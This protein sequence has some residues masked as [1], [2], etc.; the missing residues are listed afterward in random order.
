MEMKVVRR[1]PRTVQRRT[2][3]WRTLPRRQQ[4]IIE[5]PLLAESLSSSRSEQKVSGSTGSGW[6]YGKVCPP[7]STVRRTMAATNAVGTL[8]AP[9]AEL[10]A[11]RRGAQPSCRSAAAPAGY[12]PCQWRRRASGGRIHSMATLPALRRV[13]GLRSVL[14]EQPSQASPPRVRSNP[15][16]E[17]RPREAGRLGP[18]TAKACIFSVAGPRRPASRV[19]SARTLGSTNDRT[20]ELCATS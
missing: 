7:R 3:P 20:G 18:A 1:A 17:R 14:P 2:Q 11:R 9:L 10:W 12:R 15:S 8:R 16:L 19:G 13:A 4:P 5:Q 6:S